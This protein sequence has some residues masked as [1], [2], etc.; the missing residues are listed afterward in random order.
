MAK[1]SV[2]ACGPSISGAQVRVFG[3]GRAPERVTLIGDV[4][5]ATERA[6]QLAAG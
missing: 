3:P 4:M 5:R 6:K 2:D 1:V